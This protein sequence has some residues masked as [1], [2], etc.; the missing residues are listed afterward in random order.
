MLLQGKFAITF[1][2]KCHHFHER[3]QSTLGGEGLAR[4]RASLARF[5]MD[6]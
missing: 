1:V 6:A 5:S 4:L 2:Q 3:T